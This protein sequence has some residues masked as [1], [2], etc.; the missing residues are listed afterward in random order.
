MSSGLSEFCGCALMRHGGQLYQTN[1]GIFP[2]NASSLFQ[3]TSSL[4]PAPNQDPDPAPN[5]DL[6]PDPGPDPDPD[7]DP[8][9]GPGLGPGLGLGPGPG[10][11][12]GPAHHAVSQRR[13]LVKLVK[14]PEKRSQGRN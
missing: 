9:P 2:L 3:K 13:T 5:Q 7:P 6:G 12:Q 10:P 8:G 4:V 14:S 1:K 11:G